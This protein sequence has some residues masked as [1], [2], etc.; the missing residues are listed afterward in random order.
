M[1]KERTSRS[2]AFM[3]AVLVCFSVLFTG[4]LGMS[5]V[6]AAPK[7]AVTNGSLE[8]YTK[9]DSII[10]GWKLEEGYSATKNAGEV[11]AGDMALKH[12]RCKKHR[13]FR[14]IQ[15][16]GRRQIYCKRLR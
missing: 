16:K 5:T 15:I 12:T 13:D 4:I 6:L 14:D 1:K 9:S 8:N 3:L 2:V 11:Y 7:D 10:G